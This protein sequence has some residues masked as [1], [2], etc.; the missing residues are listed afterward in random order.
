MRIHLF[1]FGLVLAACSDDGP[2]DPNPGGSGELGV[3]TFTY[4]CRSAGDFT[5]PIS[6]MS[7]G[8]PAAFALGGRFGLDYDWKSE[9]DHIN[10]PLPALQSAAP[11]HLQLADDTFTALDVGYTAVLAVTGNSEVV[12]LIHASI[13]TIDSLR[14]VDPVLLPGVAPLADLIVPL[15]SSFEVQLV[16][17]D[18]NAVALSGAIDV[19]WALDAETVVHI[20]A[21]QGTG[22]VRLEAL[23]AGEATLTATV[24]DKSVSLPIS[25]D[26]S[27]DPTDGATDATSTDATTT[28]TTGTGDTT[29]D[30][31]GPGTT[32]TTDGSSGTSPD[33]D[34]SGSTTDTTG[35]AL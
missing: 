7:A 15:P 22:R 14:L 20:I 3:G 17:L 19:A 10:E 13:R 26:P 4:L 8:F 35:G 16:P 33:T 5:C 6:Q 30:A 11:T 23:A 9:S 21:G 1:V 12:D 2:T 31:T 27:L 34:T 29:A 24:G 32:G 25:V 28:I 18:L